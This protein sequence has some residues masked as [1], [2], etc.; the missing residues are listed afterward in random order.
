[1][2]RVGNRVKIFMD[3]FSLRTETGIISNVKFLPDKNEFI[4]LVAL[5]NGKG[6]VLVREDDIMKLYDFQLKL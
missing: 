6:G 3:C 5:D 2:Y 4:Y 1:M